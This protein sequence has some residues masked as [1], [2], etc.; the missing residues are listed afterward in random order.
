MNAAEKR[1]SADADLDRPLIVGLGRTGAAVAAALGRRGHEAEVIEDHPDDR[2][3]AQAESLGVTLIERPDEAVLRRA[4]DR[5]SVLLPSPGVPDSHRV[6]SLARTADVPVNSEFDLARRWDDRPIAA[7]TGT[8]GKTTVTML[9]ERILSAAGTRVVAAGNTDVPLVE[10]IDDTTTECFVVE[11]SS[12]R[13]GHTAAWSPQVATWLNFAPDHLDVH[14]DLAAYEAA[15]ASIW[16]D[17]PPGG[18]AVADLS[19]P[20]VARHAPDDAIAIGGADHRV[21]QG[22]LVVAGEPCVDVDDLWSPFP[23]DRTNALAAAATAM[24]MG[25]DVTA[26]VHGLTSFAGLPHRVELVTERAGVRWYD[27]SKATTPHATRAAVGGFASVVLIAGGRNKGISLD[28][29]VDD[30]SVLRGVVA[31]GEAA[32]EVTAALGDDVVVRSAETMTAAVA[33]AERLAR[34]GDA[35]LLS[36]GCAS[37]DWYSSYGERGDDFAALV[38]ALPNGVCR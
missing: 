9:V 38:R 34:P 12:F 14:A 4:L 1:H 28:G 17:R 22:R 19:D 7:V 2:L 10:A 32:P 29:L 23:H 21:T 36:P 8:N 5:A 3:R 37:F 31:I 27:D 25:A 33:L 24:A 16:S 11:A 30:P 20:V 6:F 26:V 35:V 18:T 13:L 15:K